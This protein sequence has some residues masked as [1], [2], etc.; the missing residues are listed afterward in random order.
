MSNTTIVDEVAVRAAVSPSAGTSATTG[1]R[2]MLRRV[3]QFV[4]RTHLYVGLFLFPWAILYGVTG[5]LFNHPTLFADAPTSTFLRA[6]VEG[7]ALGD[8]PSPREQ[9][10][11]V[12]NAL[13]QQKKP[14]SPFRLGAGEARYATRDSFIATVKADRRTFFVVFDPKTASGTIRETTP[15]RTA[16]EPAPFATGK[17]DA[18]RQRGMGMMGPMKQDHSGV[19]LSDTMTDRLKTAIPTLMERKGFPKGEVTI[20]A[21]PDVKF[22][23]VVAGN[24]W[25]ATFNPLTTS[26]TG[27]A[28]QDQSNLT[29]RGFLLRMHLTRGYPGEFNTKWFWAL[30]VD[31]IALTLCFWG[32][33]GLF[34]WWQIKATRKPG[35]VVFTLSAILATTLGFGM[36]NLLAA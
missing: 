36:Y 21:A 11:A 30:G 4:R 17:A 6:D 18:P 26:V 24:T 2:P 22:P 16:E 1:P 3:M 27:T 8:I 7:T 25:T 33:S 35:L 29:V 15:G 5:F 34:M 23:V 12:L 19:K 20:T 32:I 9:A 10:A 31:A 28:G 13:N 14:E